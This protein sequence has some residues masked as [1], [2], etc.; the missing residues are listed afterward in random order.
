MPYSVECAIIEVRQMVAMLTSVN[1]RSC[2]VLANHH[3][4]RQRAMLAGVVSK[5]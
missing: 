4:R 3:Q 2:S 1:V 5:M